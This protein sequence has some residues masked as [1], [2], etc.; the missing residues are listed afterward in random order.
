MSDV[1]ISDLAG[2]KA[3]NIHGER[4]GKIDR[5]VFQ[6][7]RDQPDWLVIKLGLLGA[8]EQ[9]V[10]LEHVPERSRGADTAVDAT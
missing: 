5:A 10:P 9:I 8:H 2:K 3:L 1:S 7:D 4:L 6:G